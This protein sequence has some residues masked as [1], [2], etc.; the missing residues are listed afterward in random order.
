[1]I[2]CKVFPSFSWSNEIWIAQGL[3]FD[4]HTPWTQY[5]LSACSPVR[6]IEPQLLFAEKLNTRI[7]ICVTDE[8]QL[9]ASDFMC[10]SNFIAQLACQVIWDQV[11]FVNFKMSRILSVLDKITYYLFVPCVSLSIKLIGSCMTSVS[12]NFTIILSRW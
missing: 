3:G 2:R 8:S 4:V 9:N 1:M 10:I 6:A 5:I 12:R 11:Q 7:Q